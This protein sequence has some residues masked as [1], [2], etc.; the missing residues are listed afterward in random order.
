MNLTQT[1]RLHA[2]FLL[3]TLFSCGVYAQEAVLTGV[4]TDAANGE[5]LIGATVQ[6]GDNGTVTDYDG[7]YSLTAQ[8]GKVIVKASYVGYETVTRTV[9][10][11]AGNNTLDFSVAEEATILNTATVTA[12]KFEKP[13]GEVT[14]SLEVIKP[15]LLE[16]NNATSVDEVLGK[17]SGVEII[18]GQAN[19]RGGSGYS[20]GAG[21]RVLLLVDDI[22]ILQPDAGFPNWDD[23]PVENIEQIEVVKGAASA[24]YG[25]SAMN[26][27]INIRTGYAKSDPETTL[28]SFYTAY[29]GYEQES[30]NW[31]KAADTMDAA[32]D[33]LTAPH[34]YGFSA[35]H[36]QK[37][38]K[39]DVVAGGYYFKRES[40][41]RNE[42]QQYGRFNLNTRYRITDR[43]S[44]GV[45][46][47]FNT[48]Q[49]QSFFYWSGNDGR[50]TIG[51]EGTESTT[52]RTRYNI[53]PFADYY[54]ESGLRH[55]LRGR[56]YSVDNRSA[57]NQSNRSQLFYGEYQIQK[58][59]AEADL[60][61]T[62]GLVGQ[63][64]AIDAE[65]YGDTL[66]TSNN[67]A[68]YLQ[69][70]K[71]FFDRLNVSA[72]LR[73]ERNVLNAPDENIIQN[74]TIRGGKE[75]EAKPVFRLGLNY[76]LGAGTYV[77]ASVGQGYRFPTIA[78]KYIYTNA[79]F[80]IRP[81]PELTSETGYTA[82]IGIKQGF[83]IKSWSGF[84]DVAYFYSE[85][86]NM[87]EFN[88]TLAPT[89]VAFRSLNVGNTQIRGIDFSIGGQ[90][91]I[92]AVGIGIIGGY[93]YT[94]PKYLEFDPAGNGQ[95]ANLIDF[96]EEPGLYNAASSSADENVLK[97]R[98]RHT[99]KLDT[100]AT[101]GAASLGFA[102]AYNSYM[103]AVDALFVG[104]LPGFR[105][106]RTEHPDGVS[107]LDIRA[108]CKITKKI[109][110][111][112]IAK[113]VLN[114]DYIRRPA[115]IEAPRSFTVRGDFKF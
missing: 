94:D 91:K 6:I 53:D 112:V 80:P 61:V 83:K 81:N 26:G 52:E 89:G 3:F 114:T 59:F 27:I 102:Y 98:F 73:Y 11:T 24:L 100:E 10:L 50:T 96:R 88:P 62:A 105:D 67:L 68:G 106:Y 33:T 107:V 87:M 47:N 40:F 75:I 86:R 65:L 16:N 37:F 57:Q 78:E 95:P 54:T 15:A 41:R 32:A 58:N 51:E 36:K 28:S 99:L 5:T 71:K 12:G 17:V 38:G 49:A 70:D 82:E 69:A 103:E 115:Y 42:Y 25:S 34:E 109:K 84:A 1:L 43:F 56:F 108:G 9:T 55:R 46:G 22:P 4:V 74:D 77:R 39:L 2:F 111:S 113:N 7:S 30:R 93:T 14:V 20:Y 21:S 63:H 45:N 104:I 110:V 79:G 85:Y 19:I 66:Y 72:G 101:L 31:W 35:L 64:S 13:L 92:G 18:D 90:G 8:A 48:G 97:Y 60:T 44:V 76:Q 23:V 29:D